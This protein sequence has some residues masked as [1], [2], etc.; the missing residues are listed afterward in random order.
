MGFL[1]SFFVPARTAKKGSTL[2][3]V[4]D[5][6]GVMMRKTQGED[7]HAQARRFGAGIFPVRRKRQRSII[8]TIAAA[9]T[10]NPVFLSG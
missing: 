7:Q 2:Y 8:D 10:D 6:T 5:V 1:F 3:V 9:R 4:F